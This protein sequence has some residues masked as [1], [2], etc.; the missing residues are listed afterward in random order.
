MIALTT[1]RRIGAVLIALTLMVFSAQAVAA[2]EHDGHEGPT[3]V[4]TG[5][6]QPRQ[7][8]FNGRGDLFIGEAGS[9][10]DLEEVG[11]YAGAPHCTG[12]TGAVT[13]VDKQ[14]RQ[15]R[16]VTGLPSSAQC[17]GGAQAGGP[18]GLVPKGRD[19]IVIQMGSTAS[20]NPSTDLTIGSD[21]YGRTLRTRKNGTVQATIADIAGFEASN[22]LDGEGY[23]SNPTDIAAYG[24]NYVVVDGGGNSVHVISNTGRLIRTVEVPQAPC[25]GGPG[26]CF[27]D[28]DLDS[29]PTG[30]VRG[31]GDTFYIS[32]LSGVV[33]DFSVSPPV[34]GFQP[35]NGKIF[36][37]NARTGDIVEFADGLTTAIDVA[38]DRQ[39][40]VVYAAEFVT[41]AVYAF[42]ADTAERTRVDQPGDLVT[43]GGLAV[44][45]SG[46]LYVSTF[47]AAPGKIGQ[48]VKYDR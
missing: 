13:R 28:E 12:L 31:L 14:G 15:R 1:A 10:G 33:A 7:L 21:I 48:V 47:T 23:D 44:D 45:R 32:T 41:G 37:F 35:G 38:F 11:F 27:G 36:A 25:P 6:D 3:V 26:N 17:D 20:I 16:V 29:V 18:T 22:D 43:P 19:S 9:G 46:D 2:E 34:I 4:A 40:N 24:R 42:D 30:V 39:A 5:L 8:A